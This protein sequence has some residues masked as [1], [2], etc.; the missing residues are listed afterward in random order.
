MATAP[1]DGTKDRRQ[2][3]QSTNNVPA[4]GITTF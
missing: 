3:L 2:S 4:S 1:A